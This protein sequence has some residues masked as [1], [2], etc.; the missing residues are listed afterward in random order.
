MEKEPTNINFFTRSGG[1]GVIRGKQVAEYLGARLNPK[2]VRDEVCIYVKFQPPEDF[3]K[4]SYLDVIDEPRRIGW[5]RDHPKMKV[6]A[7]SL[8]GYEY[9]TD[10][11]ENEV[12]LIPQ[13]FQGKE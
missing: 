9:L 7:S 5:L 12:V 13:L 10:V 3:P 1:S 6:I 11:L 8:S 4:N 2:E